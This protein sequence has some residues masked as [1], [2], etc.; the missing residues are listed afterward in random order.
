MLVSFM[1]IWYILQPFGTFYYMLHQGKSGSLA[2]LPE[3]N[4]FRAERGRRGAK[5]AAGLTS[6]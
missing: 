6:K 2:E 5:G 1:E 3:E 4:M